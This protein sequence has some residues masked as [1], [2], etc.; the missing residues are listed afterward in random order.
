M[1]DERF[2][3]AQ[4]TM[5]DNVPM[6][7]KTLRHDIVVTRYGFSCGSVWRIVEARCEFQR[8]EFR[9]LITL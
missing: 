4:A 2:S 7:N 6:S 9:S 3:E 5:E 8:P 1:E